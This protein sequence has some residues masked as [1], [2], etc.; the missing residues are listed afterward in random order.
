MKFRETYKAILNRFKDPKLEPEPTIYKDRKLIYTDK[1]GNKWYEMSAGN[2]PSERALYSQIYSEDIKF[3]LTAEGFD[4]VLDIIEDEMNS[5][6]PVKRSRVIEA[7]TAARTA[8]NVYSNTSILLNLA[9]VYS[10]LNDEDP[11]SVQDYIQKEKQDIWTK[12]STCKGF[13]LQRQFLIIQK[14]LKLQVSS[15]QGYLK[16]NKAI[17]DLIKTSLGTL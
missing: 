11:Q 15:A 10:L 6:S 12:D 7:T 3:G 2:L 1:F 9:S 5:E 8:K 4:K 14:S 16:E 17:I 13:F